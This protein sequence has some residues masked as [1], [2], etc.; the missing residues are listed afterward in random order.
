MAELATL[1]GNSSLSG[2]G[3]L[4]GINPP[5]STEVLINLSLSPAPPGIMF[6]RLTIL[7]EVT[8]D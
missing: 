4:R 5:V 1:A 6:R 2:C 8:Y 3:F 7:Y